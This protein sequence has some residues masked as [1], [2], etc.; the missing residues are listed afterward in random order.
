MPVAGHTDPAAVE[1]VP[2]QHVLIPGVDH[3]VVD[4]EPV[5]RVDLLIEAG[6]PVVVIQRL[7][8]VQIFRRQAHGNFSC[9]E[10][11]QITD[12]STRKSRRLSEPL[13]LVI[14]KE[15][16]LVLSERPAQCASELATAILIVL[17]G[18]Q[19]RARIGS[20]VAKIAVER[21]MQVIGT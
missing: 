5:V 2:N 16:S 14:C 3:S 18:L 1:C 20:F 12:Q 4:G 13:P 6:K 7:E 17:R 15:E 19:K 11:G 21:T 10:Y 8:S 9:I